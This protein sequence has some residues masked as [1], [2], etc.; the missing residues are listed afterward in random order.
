[1]QSD[2]AGPPPH[3]TLVLTRPAGSDWGWFSGRLASGHDRCIQVPG[4]DEPAQFFLLIVKA[5]LFRPHLRFAH[6]GFAILYDSAQIGPMH[7]FELHAMFYRVDPG[8]VVRE[9]ALERR[10]ERLTRSN[11]TLSTWSRHATQILAGSR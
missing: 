7:G 11:D 4:P 1:M 5:V 10:L 6:P 2:R 9:P 8:A 3:A